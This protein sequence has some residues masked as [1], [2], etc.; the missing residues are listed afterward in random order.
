MSNLDD[1][2]KLK[3]EKKKV[4]RKNSKK[5][6]SKDN[7]NEKKVIKACK[8]TSS[9]TQRVIRMVSRLIFDFS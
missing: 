9:Q 8:D 4:E 5:V 3:K 7:E 6:T 2:K 1:E